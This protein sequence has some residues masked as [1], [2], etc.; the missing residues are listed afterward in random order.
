[1]SKTIITRL[2]YVLAENVTL[3]RYEYCTD[4]FNVHGLWGWQILE[5][6]LKPHDICVGAITSKIVAQCMPR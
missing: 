4:K 2:P 6:P 5:L 3:D 1:M